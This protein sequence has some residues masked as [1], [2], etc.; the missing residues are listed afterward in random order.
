MGSS[1]QSNAYPAFRFAPRWAILFRPARRDWQGSKNNRSNAGV[2][3]PEFPLCGTKELRAVPESLYPVA[4]GA[5]LSQA[6][7]KGGFWLCFVL[8]HGF[9][10]AVM[11]YY[12]PGFSPC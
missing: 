1:S 4:G 10:R 11:D 6:A 7:E 9:S 12:H 2:T 5:R 8:G 3:R